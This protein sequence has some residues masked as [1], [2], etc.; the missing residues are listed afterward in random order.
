MFSLERATP[1]Y[2]LGYTHA[3]RNMPRMEVSGIWA[4]DYA[5]GYNAGLN[6]QYWGAQAENKARKGG[7]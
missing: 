7:K 1:K 3:A 5:D 4:T 6:D 2:R